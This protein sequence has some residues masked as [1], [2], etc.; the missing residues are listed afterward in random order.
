[1]N[2][3][4]AAGAVVAASTLSASHRTLAAGDTLRVTQTDASG[5]D[6]A[7]TSV[8]IIVYRTA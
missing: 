3:S 7:A 8:Y 2:N 1:M 6:S 4:G 5:T